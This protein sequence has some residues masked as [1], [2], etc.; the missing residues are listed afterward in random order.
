MRGRGWFCCL[1]IPQCYSVPDVLCPTEIVRS[2]IKVKIAKCSFIS[3]ILL[4][5]NS[6]SCLVRLSISVTDTELF[7]IGLF[8]LS[9]KRRKRKVVVQ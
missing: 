7:M 8:P 4:V 2:M 5:L 1:I 6:Q 3:I 9:Y